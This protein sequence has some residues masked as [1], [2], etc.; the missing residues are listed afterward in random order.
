MQFRSGGGG[1][2][3]TVGYSAAH[4]SGSRVGVG[5]IVGVRVGVRVAVGVLVAVPVLV[6]VKVMLGVRVFV[7]VFVRGGGG[8]NWVGTG[9]SPGLA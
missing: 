1:G 8:P 4:T 5:V 2:I 9:A 6:G 7:G 3:H